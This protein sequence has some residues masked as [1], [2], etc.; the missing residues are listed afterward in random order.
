MNDAK[1]INIKDYAEY[2]RK[3]SA[4]ME[5]LNELSDEI[6]EG[7]FP[8]ALLSNWK[9]WDEEQPIGSKLHVDEDML[10]NTGDK[11][12][13]IL[14]ELLDMAEDVKDRIRVYKDKQDVPEN[15]NPFEA[16]F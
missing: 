7:L 13:D 9:D 8:L 14:W 6:Y 12:I 4:I 10:R 3:L 1:I 2:N 16:D 11:N 5:K 15:F